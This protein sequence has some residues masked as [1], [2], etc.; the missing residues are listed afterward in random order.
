MT[1]NKQSSFCFMKREASYH[2]SNHANEF[3]CVFQVKEFIWP[4]SV[5]IRPKHSCY[6]ELS[7][8]P[9]LSKLP[10]HG[11][12]YSLSSTKFFTFEICF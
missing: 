9:E 7:F 6:Y 2:M 12:A 8:R 4:M 10:H 11:D 1:G 5:G 3:L